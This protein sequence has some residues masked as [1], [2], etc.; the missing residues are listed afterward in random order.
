MKVGRL[1]IQGAAGVQQLEIGVDSFSH[2]LDG[3]GN[4][5]GWGWQGKG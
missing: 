1:I 3:S 5:G 4:R 2:D